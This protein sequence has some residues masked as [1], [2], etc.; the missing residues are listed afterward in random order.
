MTDHFEEEENVAYVQSQ[1]SQLLSKLPD[2]PYAVMVTRMPGGIAGVPDWYEIMMTDRN[3]RALAYNTQTLRDFDIYQASM[4]VM[5]YLYGAPPPEPAID[6]MA[7][8]T[9]MQ[10]LRE[11]NERLVKK[12][13]AERLTAARWESA[14]KTADATLAAVRLV[15]MARLVPQ[16][17]PS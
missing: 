9:E 12:L 2:A 8:N 10:G 4:L 5:G 6:L 3:G 16:E 17:Q 15:T 11:A 1:T 14:F 7:I 13:E